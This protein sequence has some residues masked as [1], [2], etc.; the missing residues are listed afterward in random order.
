MQNIKS[1]N[2][3]LAI[4]I[5]AKMIYSSSPRKPYLIFWSLL[6]ITIFFVFQ[7]LGGG[8]KILF[9]ESKLMQ[10]DW[11][12]DLE[13]AGE[14][15]P[16]NDFYVREAWEK[17]FL[18]LLASDFQNILYLKRAPKYFSLIESEL[19]KRGLPDDLKYLAV[20]ESALRENARSSAGAQGIW[21]F[22]SSTA[23]RYGLRVDNFIDERD[24]FE[25][26]TLAALDYLTFLHAKFDSWTLAAAAYN[27]GEN[28]IARRLDEQNVGDY[29]DLYLNNE[30][31]S[32]LFRTL[33]IKEIMHD[34]KKYGYEIDKNSAF[35]W[36]DLKIQ[37]VVG[38]ID[39]L[40]KFAVENK[41]TLRA[42][43]ELNPWIVGNSLPSGSFLVK[44][45]KSWQ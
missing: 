3:K 10:I 42:I 30:T 35:A 6:I 24:H 7:M 37:T 18:V 43:K 21:Q 12:R 19:E 38:P 4:F 22:I 36:P 8:E 41:T 23:K 31:S 14:K 32:Y 5:F 9:S 11:P 27:A 16:L 20:A 44:I 13:F 15:V 39:D 26:A 17:E 28:G 29:Y 25:K 2:T 40:A 1:P 34:P 33:A 45:M